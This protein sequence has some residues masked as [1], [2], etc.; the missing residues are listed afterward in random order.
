MA[1]SADDPEKFIE[2]RERKAKRRLKTLEGY[3]IGARESR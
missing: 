2:I 1:R 3:L